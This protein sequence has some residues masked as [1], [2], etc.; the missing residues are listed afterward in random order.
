[1]TTTVQANYFI[2]SDY[3]EKAITYAFSKSDIMYVKTVNPNVC[4]MTDGDY[5]RFSDLAGCYFN[6]M[7]YDLGLSKLLLR[8]NPQ[9]L[10]TYYSFHF[11][12]GLSDC[13]LNAFM[14]SVEANSNWANAGYIVTTQLPTSPD[15]RKALLDSFEESGLGLIK[16]ALKNYKNSEIICPATQHRVTIPLEMP[17]VILENEGFKELQEEVDFRFALLNGI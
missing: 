14:Q 17:Q 3:L 13:N 15:K 12:W 6:F 8:A 16:I 7:K 4:D 5:F 9:Y 10:L 11:V 2:T 1:M